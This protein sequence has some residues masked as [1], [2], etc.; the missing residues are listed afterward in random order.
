MLVYCGQSFAEAALAALALCNVRKLNSENFGLADHEYLC[1]GLE[2]PNW[3]SNG[4]FFPVLLATDPLFMRGIDYRAPNL[5]MVFVSLRPF[6]HKRQKQQA[7]CRVGRNGDKA[8]RYQPAD[9]KILD[10]EANDAYLKKVRSFV[11]QKLT[12]LEAAKERRAA[13]KK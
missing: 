1:N 13:E 6:D 2:E 9:M 4:K 3:T 8:W 7:L 12:D 11:T 5:G 10:E